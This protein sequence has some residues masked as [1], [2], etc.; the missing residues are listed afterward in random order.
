MNTLTQKSPLFNAI[1]II[2]LAIFLFDV[3]GAII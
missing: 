1:V 3:M 2:M